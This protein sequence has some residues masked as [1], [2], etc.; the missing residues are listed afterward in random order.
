MGEEEW[1][2]FC[3]RDRKYPT[4]TRTNR[5]TETGYWKATGK[6]NEIYSKAGN[7]RKK[8]VGMKKTLV[9]Y[10]GRAPKG[11]K[12]DWVMH[13]FRLEG[14]YSFLKSEKVISFIFIHVI[15]ILDMHLSRSIFR[16]TYN[17]VVTSFLD[18]SILFTLKQDACT[19]VITNSVTVT[20]SDSNKF[21]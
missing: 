7:S 9:F 10:K 21:E 17:L 8:L 16:F 6:D 13:E 4:G 5:A 18:I 2:F 14:N 11:E 3:Q 15:P 19:F 12:M 1:Y 20:W